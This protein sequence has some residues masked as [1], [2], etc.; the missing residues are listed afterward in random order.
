MEVILHHL[1]GEGSHRLFEILL[2]GEFVCSPP[3][4]YLFNHE[5]ISVWT[6]GYLFHPLDFGPVIL[7]CV[8][9]IVLILAVGRLFTWPLCSLAMPYHFCFK[10]IFIFWH[11]KVLLVHFRYSCLIPR[12]SPLSRDPLLMYF[13][14]TYSRGWLPTF[15]RGFPIQKVCFCT[16]CN[17][18]FK[19]ED[20]NLLQKYAE[21]LCNHLCNV[22]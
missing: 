1:E 15:L 3:I 18:Y 9:Q 11:H 5:F 8:A 2:C 4:V 17:L 10:H 12:I 14:V 21:N 20:S 19:L 6:Q 7:H 22:C 16:P 13:W